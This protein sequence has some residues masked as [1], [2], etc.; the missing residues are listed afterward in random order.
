MVIVIVV[1]KGFLKVLVIGFYMRTNNSSRLPVKVVPIKINSPKGIGNVLF[2]YDQL[3]EPFR[4]WLHFF[5]KGLL[6]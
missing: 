2:S 3:P 6:T 5:F 4:I 1:G